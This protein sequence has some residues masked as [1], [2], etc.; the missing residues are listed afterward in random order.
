[1]RTNSTTRVEV[2]YFEGCPNGQPAVDLARR[3]T[4]EHG[5]GAE[6]VEVL[7]DETQVEQQRFLG[8]PTIRVDGRDVDPSAHERTIFHYG[9]RIYDTRAGRTGLP[10]DEWIRVALQ[11]A[12]GPRPWFPLRRSCGCDPSCWCRSGWRRRLRWVWPARH[13]SL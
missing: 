10:P 6:V 2:I 5:G 3:I 8:S 11:E 7:V 1:M 12:S 9:C 4:K 13:V